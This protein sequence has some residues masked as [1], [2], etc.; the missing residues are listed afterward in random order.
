MLSELQVSGFLNPMKAPSPEK[1]I[2]GHI[3]VVDA[4]RMTFLG[5]RRIL[6]KKEQ[7][8]QNFHVF[9]VLQNILTI[10]ICRN[11]M[12]SPLQASEK[13]VFSIF[14]LEKHALSEAKSVS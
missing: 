12:I 13:I 10:I 6:A 3:S 1:N 8:C 7:R 9:K 14:Q 4:G 5:E 11:F 2:V